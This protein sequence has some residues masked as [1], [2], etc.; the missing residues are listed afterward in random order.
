MTTSEERWFL[1]NSFGNQALDCGPDD[2]VAKVALTQKSGPIRGDTNGWYL[3][4]RKVERC[5]ECG[6]VTKSYV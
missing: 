3:E 6:Q 1:C 2:F 4:K 5:G